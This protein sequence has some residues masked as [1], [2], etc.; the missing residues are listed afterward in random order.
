MRSSRLEP[1]FKAKSLVIVG[2]TER[3]AFFRNAYENCRTLDF[4]DKVRLVNHKG[5]VI[6]GQTAA[7]SCA[8]LREQIDIALLMVPVS[9]L[10]YA[11]EDIAEAGI[12]NA[13]ILSSGFAEVGGN[14]AELQ[15]DLVARARE[16]GITLLGPNCLGFVNYLDKLPVFTG[17]AKDI[18]PDPIAVVS[19]SGAVASHIHDMAERRGL[20]MGYQI[21]TGNEA[22]ISSAEVIDFLLDDPRIEVVTAFLESTRDTDLLRSAAAKA[23]EKKKTII[24]LKVGTGSQTPRAAEAHTASNVG[25]DALYSA[26]CNQFGIIRVRSIEEMIATAELALRLPPLEKPQLGIVS[27]SGGVCEIASDRADAA[28]APVGPFNEGTVAKLS[29]AAASFGTVHNPL[30]LTG[31]A[32]NDLSRYTNSVVTVADDPDIGAVIAVMDPP[33]QHGIGYEATKAIETAAKISNAPVIQMSVSAMSLTEDHRQMM[34]EF[35][36]T[37]ANSGI[38]EGIGAMA[39]LFRWSKRLGAEFAPVPAEGDGGVDRPQSPE[40][41]L[42]FLDAHGIPVGD[43]GEVS[44]Q[45]DDGVEFLVRIVR[46]ADWGLYVELGFGGVW[47]MALC[48]KV[49]RVLPVSP[50]DIVEMLQELPS[51]TILQDHGGGARIDRRALANVISAIGNA[52]FE[53]GPE[54]SVLEINRLWIRGSQVEI[55]DANCSW[56]AA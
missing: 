15:R 27:I 13:V 7:L 24:A 19:Q 17:L 5:G 40:A 6:C 21:A 32:V 53:L 25:Y 56:Q 49:L 50:D 8:E 48:D 54:L 52:S 31:A 3:S 28:G 42:R 38:D 16:L 39:H 11:L 33:K 45:R 20:A 36:L 37:F 43:Q 51:G 18:V 29:E 46:D 44:P 34:S 2:A 10:F 4:E 47:S 30:D 1:L 55:R 35:D 22:D 26:A 9:Y 12:R 14:G 23:R 41:T